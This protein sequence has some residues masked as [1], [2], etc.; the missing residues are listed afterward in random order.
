M[1]MELEGSFKIRSYYFAERMYMVKPACGSGTYLSNKSIPSRFSDDSS[2]RICAFRSGWLGE[3]NPR[4]GTAGDRDWDFDSAS[5]DGADAAEKT[6]NSDSRRARRCLRRSIVLGKQVGRDRI[7]NETP[8]P[9]HTEFTEVKE[10]PRIERPEALPIRPPTVA[11]KKKTPSAP[12]PRSK[13]LEVQPTPAAPALP[14]EG[15]ADREAMLELA[16]KILKLGDDL[17][18]RIGAVGQKGEDDKKN[19]K[20]SD[21]EFQI[22]FVPF[23]QA[24]LKAAHDD[25]SK[26][27]AACCH[28]KVIAFFEKY[29]DGTDRNARFMMDDP[30]IAPIYW[31]LA[32]YLRSLAQRIPE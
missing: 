19:M 7:E 8:K 31:N 9:S 14:S 23:Q 22:H 17:H 21:E 11:P 5:F 10:P 18:N 27:Y 28:D 1:S 25:T 32:N 26:A 4:E 29:G 12:L 2:S 15:A 3:N 30:G 24:E 13:S 6:Q 20:L 16:N